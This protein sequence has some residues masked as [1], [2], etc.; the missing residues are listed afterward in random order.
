MSERSLL[1]RDDMVGFEFCKDHCGNCVEKGLG[2][3]PMRMMRKST[4]G[5]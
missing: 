3:G 5:L 1:S 4:R 2:D